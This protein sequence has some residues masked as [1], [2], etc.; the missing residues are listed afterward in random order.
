[1]P[2]PFIHLRQPESCK[3][4]RILLMPK[5]SQHSPESGSLTSSTPQ[6]LPKK[7]QELFRDVLMLLEK[8]SVPFA[9]AGAF[10]LRQHSGICRDTKDLDIFLPAADVSGALACLMNHGFQCEVCDPIWL[11]KAYRDKYFVDLIAGMSMP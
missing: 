6:R 11:A 3:P 7:Q 10:A 5:R 1:M 9:V 4:H 8:H 2:Y